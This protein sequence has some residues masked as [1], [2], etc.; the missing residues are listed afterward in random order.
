M[1][2]ARPAA[3][4]PG[5][6]QRARGTLGALGRLFRTDAYLWPLPGPSSPI[7]LQCLCNDAYHRPCPLPRSSRSRS[8]ANNP[9]T[10]PLCVN[11]GI[12]RYFKLPNTIHQSPDHFVLIV[13]CTIP[14]AYFRGKEEKGRSQAE[15]TTEVRSRRSS[16]RLSVHPSPPLPS[17][18]SAQ[19]QKVT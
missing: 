2:Y 14:R 17:A 9:H 19:V 4:D 15:R 6:R 11:G 8:P 10:R 18:P 3:G 1:A 16:R 12:G 13:L 5:K 7:L